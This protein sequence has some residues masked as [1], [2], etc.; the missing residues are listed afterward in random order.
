MPVGYPYT[1]YS[2]IWTR[3]SQMQANSTYNWPW[4]PSDAWY[5]YFTPTAGS[6]YI[7]SSGVIGELQVSP[8]TGKLITQAVPGGTSYI[9]LTNAFLASDGKSISNSY[10]IS[11]TSNYLSNINVFED[12]SGNIYAL[13]YKPYNPCVIKLNSSFGFVWRMDG[14]SGYSGFGYSATDGSGNIFFSTT[15][16]SANGVIVKLNSSGSIATQNSLAYSGNPNATGFMINFSYNATS[17]RL[18]SGAT[19]YPTGAKGFVSM[20]TSGFS[21]TAAYAMNVNGTLYDGPSGVRA[22]SGSSDVFITGSYASTSKFFV[23]RWTSDYGSSVWNLGIDFATTG[24]Y[25]SGFVTDSSNN[26]YMTVGKTGANYIIKINSSGSIVWQRQIVCV[27]GS[28]SA[29]SVTYANT[30]SVFLQTSPSSSN[31]TFI[32]ILSD[33]SLTKF[34]ASTGAVY[35][36]RAS[37]LATE[38]PTITTSSVPIGNG[39]NQGFPMSSTA[40]SA[41]SAFASIVYKNQ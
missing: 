24:M 32:R 9:G 27:Y 23:A 21:V 5:D 7:Y 20:D 3:Q 16:S 39:G 1:Q 14:T 18:Y 10:T 41:G 2:G 15:Y 19:I 33:G 13:F 30:T 12:S 6:P 25:L 26:V 38:T 17:T 28:E 22:L 31:T 34:R 36:L 4:Q 29:P 11:Y 40:E 8:N 35:E 37:S